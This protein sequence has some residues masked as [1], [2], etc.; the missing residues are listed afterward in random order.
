MRGDE[1]FSKRILSNTIF[2]QCVRLERSNLNNI[3]TALLFCS[4]KDNSMHSYIIHQNLKYLLLIYDGAHCKE[5]FP[6]ISHGFPRLEVLEIVCSLDN[7]ISSLYELKEYCT[8]IM[9]ELSLKNLRIKKNWGR[10]ASYN[11]ICSKLNSTENNTVTFFHIL[12]QLPGGIEERTRATKYDNKGYNL[13]RITS[14]EY[15][16]S[17]GDTS[18]LT[19]FIQCKELKEITVEFID[20]ARKTKYVKCFA[21]LSQ[22]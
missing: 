18:C 6:R 1:Q 9:P 8:M 10:T 15:E 19:L 4:P 20:Y 22:Q 11:R 13:T 21:E 14:E 5:M 12:F 17:K 16:E 3:S 2:K 7:Y